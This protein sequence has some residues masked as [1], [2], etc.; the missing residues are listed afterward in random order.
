MSVKMSPQRFCDWLQGFA[1]L[2][3]SPPSIGQWNMIKEHLALVYNKVTPPLGS[4]PSLDDRPK[5]SGPELLTEERVKQIYDKLRL[6]E[7]KQR[8]PLHDHVGQPMQF[9]GQSPFDPTSP[10]RMPLVTC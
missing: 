5:S 8:N 4:G 9:P 1:E 6:P 7:I 2:G 3:G 10:Y